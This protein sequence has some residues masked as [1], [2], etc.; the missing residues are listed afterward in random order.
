MIFQTIKL[1]SARFST[2][3]L[4]ISNK[5]RH[6]GRGHFRYMA[7]SVWRISQKMNS[8]N[9]SIKFMKLEPWIVHR[10]HFWILIAIGC[11]FSV[12]RRKRELNRVNVWRDIRKTLNYLRLI[13]E[14]DSHAKV[15]SKRRL[16]YPWNLGKRSVW[17]LILRTSWNWRSSW[18]ST[19]KTN[20]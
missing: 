19:A 8:S 18:I 1:I 4:R 7:K 5:R 15:K 14:L 11:K 17:N 20:W 13:K 3:S 10:F 9:Y 12:I 2:S 16:K 6:L